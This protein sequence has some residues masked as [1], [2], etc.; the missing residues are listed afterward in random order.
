VITCSTIVVV[1]ADQQRNE[2]G[3]YEDGVHAE[4]DNVKNG[5]VKK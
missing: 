5:C 2:C 1:A 3:E 4:Q